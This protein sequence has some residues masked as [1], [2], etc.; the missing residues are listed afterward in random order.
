MRPEETRS[1]LVPAGGLQPQP[2]HPCCSLFWGSRRDGEAASLLGAA[3]LPLPV[4]RAC[5]CLR[6]P[7]LL[8]MAGVEPL[9]SP[10]PHQGCLTG[11]RS[12]GSPRLGPSCRTGPWSRAGPCD[13]VLKCPGAP[14]PC[15]DS[16]RLWPEEEG[17]SVC[18]CQARAGLEAGD[19]KQTRDQPA[20]GDRP[21]QGCRRT[22]RHLDVSDS[23]TLGAAG[24]KRRL[25]RWEQPAVFTGSH[26]GPRKHRTH[27]CPS[28]HSGFSSRPGDL[29]PHGASSPPPASGATAASFSGRV[30]QLEPKE[31]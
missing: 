17:T 26:D 27:S 14:L 7:F 28:T 23:E 9:G 25:S 11:G 31:C 18:T 20:C 1:A 2:R 4:R 10:G 22:V 3:P 21:G 5:P 6:G 12:P 24:Q 16:Q 15:A 30:S 8:H 13:L 19:G 29:R